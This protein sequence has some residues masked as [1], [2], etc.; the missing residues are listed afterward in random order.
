[1]SKLGT[2]NIRG[3]MVGE[4]ADRLD[5]FRED[6]K[7]ILE[8]YQVGA[9]ARKLGVDPVQIRRWRRGNA[10]PRDT[11][12]YEIVRICAEEIRKQLSESS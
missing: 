6:L 2:L 5:Q 10:L 3:D 7:L 4:A 9:M 8:H 12:T 1:M 11:L